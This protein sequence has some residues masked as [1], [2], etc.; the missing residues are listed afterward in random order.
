MRIN[1]RP[2]EWLV[3]SRQDIERRKSRIRRIEQHIQ[4]G[5][6]MEP[7]RTECGMMEAVAA[8]EQGK[9]VQWNCGDA[10][11][12][13]DADIDNSGYLIDRATLASIAVCT[14]LR[15]AVVEDEPTPKLEIF[16]TFANPFGL[17]CFKMNGME[18]TAASGLSLPGFVGCV[19]QAG[20]RRVISAAPVDIT[21]TSYYGRKPDEQLNPPAKMVGVAF[22]R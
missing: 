10:T 9:R 8:L 16:D 6:N 18:Y 17:M 14:S 7:K 12:W 22:I 5:H 1:N 19:W 21:G 13:K 4:K 15:F 20:E 2:H 3:Q 11:Q